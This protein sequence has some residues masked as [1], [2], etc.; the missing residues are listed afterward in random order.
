MIHEFSSWWEGSTLLKPFT[1]LQTLFNWILLDK[2]DYIFHSHDRQ[3]SHRFPSCI[4]AATWLINRPTLET[5]PLLSSA[6]WVLINLRWFSW[7]RKGPAHPLFYPVTIYTQWVQIQSPALSTRFKPIISE[8][9]ASSPGSKF[10][11]ASTLIQ[12][13]S[14]NLFSVSKC[15]VLYSSKFLD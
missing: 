11:S 15:L 7:C 2:K 12:I 9:L 4:N 13:S 14:C 3:A 5:R 10:S 8:A 6:Y 1:G